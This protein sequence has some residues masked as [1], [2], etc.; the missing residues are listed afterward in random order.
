MGAKLENRF[1]QEEGL[2][3]S[4]NGGLSTGIDDPLIA[5]RNVNGA[6]PAPLAVAAAY[7]SGLP[8]PG[9]LARLH[10]CVGAGSP[11]PG[12]AR[13]IVRRQPRISPLRCEFVRL[14][15]PVDGR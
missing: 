11:P 6:N 12:N 2:N 7:R 9:S 3:A 14:G 15:V 4:Y 8:T 5:S 13:R 10:S 1:F